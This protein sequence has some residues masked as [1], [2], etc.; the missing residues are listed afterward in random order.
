MLEAISDSKPEITQRLSEYLT[1]VAKITEEKYEATP[2]IEYLLQAVAAF[3]NTVS[4]PHCR[5]SEPFRRR[6]VPIT[7]RPTSH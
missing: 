3:E 7:I 2:G 4:G 1:C 5:V 6:H